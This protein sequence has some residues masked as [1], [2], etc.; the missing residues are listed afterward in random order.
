MEEG[1]VDMEKDSYYYYQLGIASMKNGDIDDAIMNF[2]KS[3][4]LN[5]HFKTY[6]KLYESYNLLGDKNRAKDC[7]CKAYKENPNNDRIAYLYANELIDEDEETS[8]KILRDIVI[9]N[10]SY[11]PAIQML[12]KYEEG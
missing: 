2:D 5:R 6:E 7:I 9:R 4:S 11:K 10:K 8:L 1:N 3:I 12:S